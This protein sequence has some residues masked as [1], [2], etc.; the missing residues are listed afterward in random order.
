MFNHQQ[1]NT[2]RP[3][4][5]RQLLASRVQMVKRKRLARTPGYRTPSSRRS[6]PPFPSVWMGSVKYGLVIDYHYNRVYS[7][8]TERYLLCVILPTKHFC[9]GDVAEQAEQQRRKTAPSVERRVM[10]SRLECWSQQQRSEEKG[11]RSLESS[12]FHPHQ[13]ESEHEHEHTITSG[14]LLKVLGVREDTR[15]WTPFDRRAE[16]CRTTCGSGPLWRV[17]WHGSRLMT[18]LA[19]S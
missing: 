3:R 14:D 1:I 16:T 15:T 9:S 5:T 10:P 13:E 8:L 6:R 11:T 12:T 18:E 17:F 19:E 2:K 4:L 7:H